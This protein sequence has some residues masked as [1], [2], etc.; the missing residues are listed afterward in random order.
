MGGAYVEQSGCSFPDTLDASCFKIPD[1]LPAACPT[2]VTPQASQPCT[3]A[4][5][6]LCYDANGQY[7]DSTM[8][9]KTGY[10]VCAVGSSGTGKWSCASNTAWPCPNG[11]GCN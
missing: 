5:C 8:T 7:Y 1:A 11:M 4:D 9:L 10:C 3:V 6:T 2:D